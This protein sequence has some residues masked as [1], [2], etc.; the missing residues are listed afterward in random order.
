M[1]GQFDSEDSLLAAIFALATANSVGLVE[2][3]SLLGYDFGMNLGTFSG[4][5]VSLSFVVALTILGIVYATNET[6]LRKLDDEYYVAAIATP[7]LMVL[8]LVSPPLNDFVTTTPVAGFVVVAIE[9]AGYA[10]VSYLA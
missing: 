7:A 8:M 3:P 1:R 9:S 10:A 4:I 6:D 2:G 5:D